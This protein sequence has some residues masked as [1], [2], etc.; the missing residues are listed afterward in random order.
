MCYPGELSPA[1]EASQNLTANQTQYRRGGSRTRPLYEGV[2]PEI[3][4]IRTPV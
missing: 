4:L 1:G 3:A 2:D